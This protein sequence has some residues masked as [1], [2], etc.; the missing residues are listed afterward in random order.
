MAEMKRKICEGLV[1]GI[2]LRSSGKEKRTLLDTLLTVQNK[3]HV[4]YH[5]E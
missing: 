5:G 1:S 3:H 2:G 4:V